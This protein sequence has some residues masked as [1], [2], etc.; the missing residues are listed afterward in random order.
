MGI[1]LY[2]KLNLTFINVKR[3]HNSSPALDLRL[4]YC[5]YFIGTDKLRSRAALTE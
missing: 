1:A 2:R 3:N 4:A 5:N